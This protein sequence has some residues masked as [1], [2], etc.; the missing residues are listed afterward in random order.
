LKPASPETIKVAFYMTTVLEY[1]GGLEK[2]LI[3]TAAHLAEA[4]NVTA[5]VISMDDVHTQRIIQLLN[6]FRGQKID[7]ALSYKL[8]LADIRARL[9]AAHYY[10]IKNFAELR[11][12]LNEY[13]VVYSK[14]EILEA[15]ILKFLVG[16][17]NIPPV[18]FGGHTPLCYPRARSFHAKLHN[19]LYTGWFYRFL[20]SGV[21][22]FHVLNQFEHQ[23]YRRLFPRRMVYKINNPFD[24]A[25]YR[26]QARAHHHGFG[27]SKAHRHILWA[28]RLSEQKGVHTL[29]QLITEL[30]PKAEGVI[31]HIVGDGED[32]PAIERLIRDH[33]NVQYHGHVDPALMPSVY[34][35]SDLFLSTSQW[36]GYPYTLLE[37]R[38]FDLPIIAFNIPGTKDIL[39]KYD[40]GVLVA[41]ATEMKQALMTALAKPKPV[42][43]QSDQEDE[44]QP[45][46]IYRQLISALKGQS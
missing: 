20:S 19:L 38:A 12:K 43:H 22:R 25:A 45:D 2:Y 46:Y 27:F 44:F 9:G 17:K 14:N 37:A 8:D 4:E 1:G 42:S 5:D 30:T 23:L 11:K 34:Q 29:V 33:A 15:F 26:R 39:E 16:Y 31:W 40:K 21:D 3:D 7:L 13:D 24:S 35:D 36:E 18:I 6:V 32:R 41:D 28:G 10:K